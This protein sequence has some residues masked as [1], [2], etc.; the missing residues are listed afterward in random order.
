M[1][2]KDVDKVFAVIYHGIKLAMEMAEE[3]K[4]LPTAIQSVYDL[5]KEARNT[6]QV[7]KSY[8]K[9]SQEQ[10]GKDGQVAA[11]TTPPGK[12][13]GLLALADKPPP[14][15]KAAGSAGSEACGRSR[16]R[17]TATKKEEPQAPPQPPRSRVAMGASSSS[18]R[19]LTPGT[20][21]PLERSDVMWEERETIVTTHH[22]TR[23]LCRSSLLTS[24][25][26]VPKLGAQGW[27]D[28]PT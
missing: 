5:K 15:A 4:L 13:G 14:A 1:A 11:A 3:Q 20:S 9:R 22:V 2:D 16:K 18:H 10:R 21:V 19:G 28:T 24:P 25:N 26:V 8:L 27:E 23:K 6:K 12:G 7:M 17:P